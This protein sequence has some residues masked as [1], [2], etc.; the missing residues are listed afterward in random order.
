MIVDDSS[1]SPPVL[2]FFPMILS[3]WL[4]AAV[5]SLFPSGSICVCVCMG[6]IAVVGEMVKF[7]STGA[8]AGISD[9]ADFPD[10]AG[11]SGPS[12]RQCFP[13]DS[14]VYTP[15]GPPFNIL[16]GTLHGCTLSTVILS[17]DDKVA[18]GSLLIAS[19]IVLLSLLAAALGAVVVFTSS[20]CPGTTEGLTGL[21][22][23]P[24]FQ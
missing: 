19:K 24:E 14:W 9:T 15:S 20:R 2:L 16:S 6:G 22:L 3:L 21:R 23:P 4:S 1:L 10:T 12:E 18:A 7:T 11:F 8:A 5:A 13:N 17:S